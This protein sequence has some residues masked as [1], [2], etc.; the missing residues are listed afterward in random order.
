MPGTS[1]KDFRSFSDVCLHIGSSEVLQT[2]RKNEIKVYQNMSIYILP[3]ICL[4]C[5]AFLVSYLCVSCVIALLSTRYELEWIDK[6]GVKIDGKMSAWFSAEWMNGVAVFLVVFVSYAFFYCRKNPR[7]I[8]NLTG[9]V[10]LL[11]IF[12]AW[13]EWGNTKIL[14]FN[15][16]SVKKGK[17]RRL[18]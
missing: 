16:F 18:W 17:M 5:G 11:K 10:L 15:F 2:V 12:H 1:V 9:I 13:G 4:S 3:F 14:E 6:N 7:T 8:T